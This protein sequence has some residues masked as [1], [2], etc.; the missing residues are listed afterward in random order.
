MAHK[1][2]R[3]SNAALTSFFE[4][5]R[6]SYLEATTAIINFEREVQK[7]CSE[8]LERNFDKYVSALQPPTELDK[9]EIDDY[10]WPPWGEKF[11]GSWRSVGVAIRNKQLEPHVKWWETYCTLD[12][13][14]G[15]CFAGIAEWIGGP[16]SKSEQMFERLRKLGV[17][18]YD[19]KKGAGIYYVEKQIGL[20]QLIRPEEAGTFDEP[21]ERLVEQWIDLWRKVG[22]MKGIFK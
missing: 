11:D 13:E 6:R 20:S 3:E 9:K 19:E 18:M 1:V 5:G 10:V 2:P 16:K 7:K 17:A 12:W 22:G 4:E 15:E 14:D 8:V 21:L